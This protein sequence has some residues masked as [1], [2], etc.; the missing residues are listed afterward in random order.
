MSFIRY[1]GPLGASGAGLDASFNNVD[2]SENLISEDTDLIQVSTFE[3]Q[4]LLQMQPNLG[5]RFLQLEL[6]ELII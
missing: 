5:H 1:E 6:I 3:I 4:D 2:I